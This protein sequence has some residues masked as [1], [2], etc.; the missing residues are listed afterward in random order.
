MNV[1]PEELLPVVETT[2]GSVYLQLIQHLERST[3]GEL[4][5]GSNFLLRKPDYS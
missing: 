2:V 1:V 5:S 4:G 3:V